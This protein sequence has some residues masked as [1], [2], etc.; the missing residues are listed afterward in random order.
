LRGSEPMLTHKPPQES[1]LTE[2]M[3]GLPASDIM[4][5]D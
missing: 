1:I 5:I 3:P 2:H 4:V